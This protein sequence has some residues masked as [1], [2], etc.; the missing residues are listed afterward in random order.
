MSGY[1]PIKFN[2]MYEDLMEH[3]KN[4]AEAI[5]ASKIIDELIDTSFGGSNETQMKAVQLLKGLATSDD[6]ASNA[7]MKKL[8]AWTSG[9]KKSESKSLTESIKSDI[10]GLDLGIDDIK[11]SGKLITLIWK[12][13]QG[14]SA[15]EIAK[16]LKSG[17]SKHSDKIKHIGAQ[18]QGTGIKAE[19]EMN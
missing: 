12:V 7:F 6:A 5:D 17:L 8:D 13:A 2:E 14:V 19:I 15:E 1:K 10:D 16:R 9:L 4:I 3:Q 18:K 11:R